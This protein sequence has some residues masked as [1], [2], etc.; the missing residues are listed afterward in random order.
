MKAV[1]FYD[2]N[3]VYGAN[4]KEYNPLP[5]LYIKDKQGP[6][7]TCWKTSFF[8][9]LKFLFTNRLWAIQL[10]FNAPLQPIRLETDR[11][12]VYNKPTDNM[13]WRQKREYNAKVKEAKRLEEEK[14]KKVQE[15]VDRQKNY[16][17]HMK[18]EK[19]GKD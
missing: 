10:T 16:A 18:V 15:E 13:N 3:I 14:Q 2:V 7:I 6:V 8:S 5:A 9:R 12:M 1:K 17:Q 4:Q 19:G 11:K